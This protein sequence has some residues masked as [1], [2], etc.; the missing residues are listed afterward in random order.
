MDSLVLLLANKQ[1]LDTKLHLLKLGST[2]NKEEYIKE[3]VDSL[4]QGAWRESED[5]WS[6]DLFYRS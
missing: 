1:Y 2:Q 6:A 4:N 3:N 5:F